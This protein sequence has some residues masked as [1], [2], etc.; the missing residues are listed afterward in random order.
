[1]ADYKPGIIEP[2]WQK[3]WAAHDLDRSEKDPSRPKYYVLEMFPYPSGKLHMGHMR[4]YSIGDVL[5]RYLRMKGYNVLHPMGWD[6]FGLPAENAA[7]TNK[8]N[9][10]E[11]VAHN[12]EQMK[13]QQN[14][15]GISYDWSR[16]ITTSLPDYYRWTQWLFLLFYK[17]GLA[18]RKKSSINWCPECLTV[19]ANE[20]VEGG[21][22]WRCACEVETRELE[23]WFLRITDYADR[24]LEDLDLLEDWPERVKVMQQNWIGRS[25][26][27]EIVFPLKEFPGESVKVFTTRPDTLYGVTYMVLAPEHPLVNHLVE[28]TSRETEIK[29]FVK[30]MKQK[31]EIERTSAETEKIGLFTGRSALN[32]VNGEEV[33]ILVGNYVLMGYG[34]G[35]V[36]GVP[37]HDQRDFLFARKYGLPVKVVITP[38]ETVLGPDME[39]A[40][41]DPGYLINSGPFD[42]L[43]Y[44]DAQEK[45]TLFLAEKGMGGFKT[46]Y[47]L[48]DWLISRQRY[49]GA[50]IPV[51]YCEKCGVLPLREE[52]L[53]VL[54]PEDVELSGDRVPSLSHYP[55]FVDTECYRCGGKARR[56]T[57]TLDTF[58]CSSW[59][60]LRY[61]DPRNGEAAF[62]PGEANYWMPVDQYIGGIEHAV[63]H[64][65]YARFFTKVLHD[66]GLCEAVEPFKRLL[67]QGMVYKDGFKM[68]KSKGNVVTPDE[69]IEKYGADTGRMFILFASPPE[70]DLEWSDRGAEGC[71][72]F[73]R[74][75]WRLID[76]YGT[77][78]HPDTGSVLPGKEESDLHHAVHSTIKKVTDDIGA[79]FSFNTAIS[80]I[81]ELVNSTYDYLR[82]KESLSPIENIYREGLTEAL[83]TIVILLSPFA[84]HL[85]EECW[86]KLGYTDSVHLQSWPVHDRDSLRVDEVEIVVQVNGKLR[87]KLM[88][89]A[90]HSKEELVEAACAEEKIRPYIDGKEIVRT[91]AVPG[92]L[93]NLVVK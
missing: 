65:L 13:E 70:R 30:K 56:E 36:M 11:W 48:R 9:P 3:Y 4:V 5:A 16:E 28:G 58:M 57:D 80:A 59:Y 53:P 68:S 50:P 42:G 78:A 34:T 12:I 60:F 39:E 93:V 29:S 76:Q 63:M 8:V 24:L 23:Q 54:L 40:F 44:E 1:M 92:K 82:K 27:T 15:L 49:W 69:I 86:G 84:P 89:S 73:L 10:A 62:S 45:I 55:S 81:M 67:A 52:D 35:A 75:V 41:E 90:E 6:A 19:L 47:R 31:T 46:S 26:G 71:Y 77:P 38:R 37:A 17:R 88:V 14:S 91:I 2:K 25:E 79:R 22:C 66:A 83:E 64:L 74:R 51:I 20:Q 85:A 43:F 33:P 87:A 32:P 21:L 72:R 61:A 7:I 18:Y